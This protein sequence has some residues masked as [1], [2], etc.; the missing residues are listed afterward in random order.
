MVPGERGKF[1]IRGNVVS[2]SYRSHWAGQA[3]NPSPSANL[4]IINQLPGFNG[5]LVPHLRHW[6]SSLESATCHFAQSNKGPIS[7]NSTDSES[8][9]R[10]ERTRVPSE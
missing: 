3:P 10:S 1:G 6:F 2:P 8:V 4:F 5:H 9:G 7:L